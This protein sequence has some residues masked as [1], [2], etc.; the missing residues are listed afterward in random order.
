MHYST[1]L[2]FFPIDNLQMV[3]QVQKK[4]RI[5]L[6]RKILTMIKP[7][8]RVSKLSC[9][10]LSKKRHLPLIRPILPMAFVVIEVKFFE[11]FFYRYQ[12]DQMLFL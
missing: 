6:K 12:G 8:D 5:K 4:L 2:F 9:L 10:T 11:I 1:K 7:L 3:M